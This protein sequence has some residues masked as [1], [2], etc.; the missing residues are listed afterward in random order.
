MAP[1]WIGEP[2]RWMRQPVRTGGVEL[3]F[4]AV[5]A[6]CASGEVTA[7][8]PPPP[9]LPAAALFLSGPSRVLSVGESFTIAV[10]ATDSAGRMAKVPPLS[11]STI[12][13]AVATIASNGVVTAVGAGLAVVRAQAGTLSA[14][15]SVR[16][17]GLRVIIIPQGEFGDTLVV[18]PGQS[19]RLTGIE[20]QIFSGMVVDPPADLIAW[21][22]SDPALARVD[23]SWL[24]GVV[25]GLAAGN[26]TVTLSIGDLRASRTIR[27]ESTP[28]AA[29]VR[30]LHAGPGLTTITLTPGTAPPMQLGFGEVWEA[31]VP[32]GTLQILNPAGERN[33]LEPY[34]FEIQQFTGFLPAQS[35]L[36][37]IVIA[38]TF[39]T[40]L[41]GQVTLLPLWDLNAPVATN[42][43]MVRVVLTTEMGYNVYIVPPGA[44]IGTV[45]LQGCYLD[46]P[47]GVTA[48]ASLNAGSYDVVLQD[49]KSL[50]AP[51]STRFRITP[52]PGRATT[53]VL[54]GP[55]SALQI[56]T[57]LDQ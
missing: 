28:G 31:T 23:P 39:W 4:V 50:N 29:T 9:S 12:N 18:A 19:I 38:N 21:T 57:L 49:G 35:R 32:A 8:P 56:L 14:Q 46:W 11:W 47:Y 6:S 13:P 16:V 2:V 15:L 51:E 33:P 26:V 43:V 54:V 55:P 30:V 24:T 37:L 27:V 42:Q 41:F 34:S 45:F 36:T 25:T 40:P 10:T 7:V 53:Y 52:Q 3:L 17:E 1:A 48:Y 20:Y 44:P 22:S 5:V